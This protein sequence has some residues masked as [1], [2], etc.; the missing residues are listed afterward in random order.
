MD[1]LKIVSALFI[2]AMLFMLY[3]RLKH[4]SQ[5][6]PKGSKEDWL[7]VIKPLLMVVLFVIVLIVLVR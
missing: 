5:N 3:P 7:G 2:V 4:A 1:W 6:A